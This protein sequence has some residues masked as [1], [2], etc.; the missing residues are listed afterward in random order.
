MMSACGCRCRERHGPL[1]CSPEA[2]RIVK[3]YETDSITAI[4][5]DG[6]PGIILD[7]EELPRRGRW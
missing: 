7:L 3:E 6:N 5:G 1:G 2:V 4:R